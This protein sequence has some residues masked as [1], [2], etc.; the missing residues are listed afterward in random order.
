MARVPAQRYGTAAKCVTQHEPDMRRVFQES[1]PSD[2]QGLPIIPGGDSQPF[3]ARH[4][5]ELLRIRNVS[6]P[7]LKIL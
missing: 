1:D 3:P 5:D 7:G 4:V 6:S 2:A